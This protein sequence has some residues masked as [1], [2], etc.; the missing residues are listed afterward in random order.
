MN[1]WRQRAIRV[2]AAYGF[3]PPLLC[4]AYTVATWHDGEHRRLMLAVALI[5]LAF[6]TGGWLAA[7]RLTASRLWRL[8]LLASVTANLA[9]DTVLG[10]LDGGVAGPLGTLVPATSVFLAIVLQPP[11]FVVFWAASAVAY[12][13]LVIYG[14]PA[15][16]GYAM[17]HTLAFGAAALLC[18][19]HSAVLSS[20]R[21][22]LAYTSR[23]DPL[24]GCLNRRGFDEKLAAAVAEGKPFTLVLLD[25][26]H[27]KSVN[28]TYGHQAG[29]DLLAWAGASV[30]A[31]GV[32]GRLGGDEFALLLPSTSGIAGLRARLD[33][34][35]PSSLG[36]AT[37]PAVAAE[38]L[39]AVADASLYR[40][41]SGK[42]KIAASAEQVAFARTQATKN[43]P[44]ATV[45]TRERRRHS[46]ADPGWMAMAQTAVALVYVMFFRTG[47]HHCAAMIA[48][49]VWGFAAGLAVVAA[50]DWL[51]RTRMARPLML[52]YAASSFLSCA[53]IAALDGGVDSPLGVGMLLSIPLLM[54]GMRPVVAA[55]V[56]VAAGGLYVLVAILAG[57]PGFWYVTINLLGTAATAVACAVQ[58]RA[59]ADQRRKLTRAASVD[60]LT[61]VLNRR[62]FAE[63]FTASPGAG[64]LVI[65]LDGFKQL[66]D[67]HGHA[68][69]DDLLRWV[70]RTLLSSVR[71]EHR[72]GRLGGD[73]F[74]A[75]VDGDAHAI[76]ATVRDA[77]AERTGASIG[78]AV[79]G[80]DGDDFDAL[81]V[82][83]D[84][85]LYEQKKAQAVA[86]T[87]VA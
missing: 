24:T 70:A 45:E 19:R 39:F 80:P 53:A 49:C 56:A 62:G 84:A 55:P 29:D 78:V 64:L 48:I 59:A 18:L 47:H 77:L 23:T 10:L 73:E 72:V 76:A 51:S 85:R 38:D 16:P 6:A 26:D 31:A 43:G 69:G 2:A 1:Q 67:A 65:D 83:A 44:A 75:L 61:G 87:A 27:F 32:A 30:R 5:M 60:A 68:A 15:P 74:V 42:T 52:A 71:P 17:V 33:Q 3:I 25:L 46:I 36:Y 35:T 79:A 37:F 22:R 40:D 4:G 50:A 20:L 7:T 57:D 9:G 54:L 41:K 58:G 14:D 63:D 34:A 66:N 8:P 21:R 11:V 28:D 13:S 86:R 12:G 82:V 81:Y